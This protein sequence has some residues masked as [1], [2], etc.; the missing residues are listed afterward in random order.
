MDEEK[1]KFLENTIDVYR[2]KCISYKHEILIK[3]EAIERLKGEIEIFKTKYER[4]NNHLIQ[5]LKRYDDMCK[6]GGE[7]ICQ[8][9]KKELS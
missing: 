9:L 4:T 3:E 8:W 6:K 2:D 5:C 1:K 7:Q